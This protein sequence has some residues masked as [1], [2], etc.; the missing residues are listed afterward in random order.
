MRVLSRL[1]R[2]DTPSRIRML[3]C[4][5]IRSLGG[6]RA[7]AH[8]SFGDFHG[9]HYRSGSPRGAAGAADQK[10]NIRLACSRVRVSFS[11]AV[12]S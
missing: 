11:D 7:G 8:G 9:R 6:A 5:Q 3:H 10:S 2:A 4:S 12:P 1:F